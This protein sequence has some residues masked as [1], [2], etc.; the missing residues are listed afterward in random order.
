MAVVVWHTVAGLFGALDTVL[1]AV[2]ATGTGRTRGHTCGGQSSCFKHDELC[3]ARASVSVG[4]CKLMY[5]GV[6]L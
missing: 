6:R 1:K 3:C 4:G 5:D 2:F